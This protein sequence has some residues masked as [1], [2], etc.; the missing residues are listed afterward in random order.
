MG[1]DRL[2]VEP[3]VEMDLGDVSDVD[4]IKLVLIH[5]LPE[6][7][8]FPDVAMFPTGRPKMFSTNSVYPLVLD[9]SLRRIWLKGDPISELGGSGGD[10]TALE[11]KPD[12]DVPACRHLLA[13]VA[14]SFL[15]GFSCAAHSIV[16]IIDKL[17]YNRSPD[18][19]P[20]GLSSWLSST[21]QVSDSPT[22]ASNL[23]RVSKKRH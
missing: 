3:G 2:S 11:E 22:I 17:S 12:V 23:I 7:R 6:V 18:L 5:H 9:G 8:R 1:L 14:D 15:S 10:P 19:V 13:S 21:T 16:D 20:Y 4:E